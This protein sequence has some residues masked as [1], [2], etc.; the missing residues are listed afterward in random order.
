MR[1]IAAQRAFPLGE[2]CPEGAEEV[3]F[4]LAS[5]FK[6]RQGGRRNAAPALSPSEMVLLSLIPKRLQ[7]NSPTVFTEALR[8]PANRPTALRAGC[9]TLTLLSDAANGAHILRED[10]EAVGSLV[11]GIMPR[12]RALAFPGSLLETASRRGTGGRLFWRPAQKTVTSLL[13][14]LRASARS[15]GFLVAGRHRDWGA[16]R[17]VTVLNRMP[18]RRFAPLPHCGGEALGLR[19]TFCRGG[20]APPLYSLLPPIL[21]PE[22]P[23]SH[24]AQAAE[25]A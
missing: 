14:T 25:L 17:G 8:T 9:L 12:K 5:P 16:A 15:Q 24:A 7:R 3:V 4:P 21:L 22:L 19:I 11:P 2:R 10:I 23:G 1:A 13:R 20:V 6:R 18:H